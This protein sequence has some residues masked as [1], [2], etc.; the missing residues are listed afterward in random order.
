M[1]IV[2]L[3]IIVGVGVGL[4]ADGPHLLAARLAVLAAR[5]VKQCAPRADPAPWSNLHLLTGLL[6]VS[7][8]SPRRLR[9]LCLFLVDGS[10]WSC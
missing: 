6:R 9:Q 7:S 5:R 10:L 1:L 2:G 3:R 4:A 8:D